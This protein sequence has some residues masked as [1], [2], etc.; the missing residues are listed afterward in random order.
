MLDSLDSGLKSII[1]GNN[2]IIADVFRGKIEVKLICK[3]CN[4]INTKTD[5]FLDLFLAVPHRKEL[6]TINKDARKLMSF[7]DREKYLKKS[8]KV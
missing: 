2:S 5:D 6:K 8:D 3:T 4:K 7:V 1:P